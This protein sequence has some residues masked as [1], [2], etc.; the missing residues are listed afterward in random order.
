MQSVYVAA[1]LGDVLMSRFRPRL[2]VLAVA[3]LPL[4]AA[5]ESNTGGNSARNAHSADAA[6]CASMYGKRFGGARVV[7]TM[8]ARAPFH[9]YWMNSAPTANQEARV[10]FCRLEAIAEPVPRSHIRME[11]WL[12]VA[13][14]WNGRFLGIGAGGSMGDVNRPWLADGVNRGFAAVA[15]DNGHRSPS[16][17]DRNEWALGQ[18]EVIAD[19]GHRAHRVATEAGQAATRAYYGKRAAYSYMLGGSQGGK[20]ALQAAQRYPEAY[21]GVLAFH[22]VTSWV[23]TMTQQA[24]SVRALTET[25][26]SALSI[27]QMQALQDAAQAQCAGPNGLIMD[28]IRCDFDPARLQCPHAEGKPCLNEAQIVA[29]RKLY[30]GPRRADGTRIFPGFA[31]GSER[32]WAQFYRQVTADGT[33]GGGSWL[34]VYRYMVFDD[35]SWTLDRLDF[36]RDPDFAKRKLGPV[37]DADDPNLD[38]F[39]KRGGK[40]LV[41]QGWS[42]QQIPPQ[43]SIDYHRAVV[44]RRPAAE[45]DRYFRLFMVPGMVH[46]P[47]DVPA[48]NAPAV[49][50][51]NLRPTGVYDATVPLTPENDAL[52]ALQRWVEH[53]IPP[54]HFDVRVSV[55]PAGLTPRG[56]RACPFPRVAAYRGEGDPMRAENWTCGTQ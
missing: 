54:T 10:P 53:G 18:P 29:V 14:Q 21:D 23:H 24:W 51:P 38:R 41:V 50:G 2:L 33:R 26:G 47:A 16:Y 28:P 11:I 52:T 40:L 25:P 6:K 34:G 7:A 27:E 37:L 1:F 22:P 15:T 45:V 44:A 4:L 30:D 17:R 35:P 20:K 13:A 48:P 5:A 36:S 3:A 43:Q 56:V 46:G 8:L 39:H 49:P 9:V 12:P 31:P 32:L 42:D 19:F 55:M